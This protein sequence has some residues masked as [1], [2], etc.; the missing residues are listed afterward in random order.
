LGIRTPGKPEGVKMKGLGTCEVGNCYK[1]PYYHTVGKSVWIF[2]K[3]HGKQYSDKT[4]IEIK[5]IKDGRIKER[6]II[7]AYIVLTVVM[8][9]IESL[10]FLSHIFK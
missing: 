1:E 9:I 8:L 7:I 3:E 10:P 5:K 4:G 2:C 6:L